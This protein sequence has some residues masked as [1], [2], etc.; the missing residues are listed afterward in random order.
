MEAA[1]QEANANEGAEKCNSLTMGV[2]KAL[3]EVV[4]KKELNHPHCTLACAG[5]AA[6]AA[7]LHD[8]T[9]ADPANPTGF[10]RVVV[11]VTRHT[12]VLMEPWH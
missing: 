12:L 2:T 9:T 4:I 1:E 11:R 6:K 7:D 10:E 8:W 3:A 5:C